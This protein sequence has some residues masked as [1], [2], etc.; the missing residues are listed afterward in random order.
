MK[1]AL[2]LLALTLSALAGQAAEKRERIAVLEVALEGDAPPELRARISA[3]LDGGLYA[4]G[5]EVVSRDEV[6]GK[7]R[8]ARSRSKS[9]AYGAFCVWSYFKCSGNT[10][11]VDESPPARITS[12]LSLPDHVCRIAVTQ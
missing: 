10:R 11:C 1:R 12:P 8:N 4:A 2:T 3:S 6:A 9:A 5:W 7:L